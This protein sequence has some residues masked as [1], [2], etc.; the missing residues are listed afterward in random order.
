[1][2]K[3][4]FKFLTSAVATAALIGTLVNPASAAEGSAFKDISDSYAEEAIMFLNQYEILMGVSDTEFAPT[5]KMTREQF[6]TMLVKAH[7]PNNAPKLN[8]AFVDNTKQTEWYYNFVQTAFD[9][10][11][12]SGVGKN[13]AGQDVFGVGQSM[14][15]EQALV[16]TMN[17]FGMTDLV[18]PEATPDFDDADKISDWAKGYVA[19]AQEMGIAFG[20]GNGMFDP[21]VATTREMGAQMLFKTTMEI[22]ENG[23]FVNIGFGG[24]ENVVA[25]Q[26]TAFTVS[27]ATLNVPEEMALRYRA[28]L[29]GKDGTPVANQTISYQ[30]ELGWLSFTTDANGVAFFGPAAGFKPA[31]IGLE[32]EEGLTTNFKTTMATAGDYTLKVAFVDATTSEVLGAEFTKDF[33]V[34]A[35]ATTETGTTETGTTETGTTETGTTE[36]GTTETGTTETGTVVE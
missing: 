35:A 2:A 13:K 18:D 3:N 15:R 8:K 6:A 26:E 23:T 11:I 1:M 34:A 7:A 29:V 32:S 12:M 30:T 24:F 4:R 16:A 21:Q 9:E 17:M 5:Q 27:A 10:K 33:T 14:T 31:E 36:T 19:L 22:V 25:G 20:T 28:T